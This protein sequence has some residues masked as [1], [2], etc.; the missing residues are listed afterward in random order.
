MSMTSL[1][2]LRELRADGGRQA[3]T[4]GAHAA[5]GEPQARM[6]EVAVLRGPHLVLADAGGDDGLAL[7]DA[8]DLFD[9]VVRLDLL[10]GAVVIHR[11]LA[12]EL[13]EIRRATSNDRA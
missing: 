7:R 5:R 3:E 13:R 6:A 10:A 11:V 9:D 1:S 2:G 8:V 12:L 4:H